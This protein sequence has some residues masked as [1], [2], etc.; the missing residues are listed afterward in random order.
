MVPPLFPP[1]ACEPAGTSHVCGGGWEV[2]PKEALTDLDTV[3]SEPETGEDHLAK[4]KHGSEG[5]E[6]AHGQDAEDVD[7]D[8]GQRRVDESQFE[9][10]NGQSSDGEGGDNHVG[11]QPL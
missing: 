4:S 9:N 7:E 2:E 8:N 10:G 5:G 3:V 1:R 11:G 6:E